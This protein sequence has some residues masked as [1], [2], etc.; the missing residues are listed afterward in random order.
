ME[1]L[2]NK[3]LVY[4]NIQKAYSIHT[5]NSYQ[6]D[7]NQFVAYCAGNHTLKIENISE[8]EIKNYIYFLQD[9]Q[10]TTR[11][12]ARKMSSIKSWWKYLQMQG[13][14]KQ[15]IFQFVDVPKISKKLPIFLEDREI[16]HLF[17]LLQTNSQNYLRDLSILELLYSTGLRVSEL[18]KMNMIDIDFYRHEIRIM[19][20]REKERIVIL[21]ERAIKALNDYSKKE[22]KK[23]VKKQNERAVFVNSTGTR[24]TTR[25]VQRLFERLGKLSGKHITPHVLRHSFATALLNNGA[26]LRVVQELLGHSSLQT[27]QIYTHVSIKKLKEVINS[28]SF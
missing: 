10:L 24:L 5:V 4:L 17:E 27:T 28:V 6:G 7:L 16:T 2:L 12:I 21:G 8:R 25:T 15:D 22:R 20:K 18:V 13:Y 23:I 9:T 14:V 11:S 1:E 26:D 19:G 3:F